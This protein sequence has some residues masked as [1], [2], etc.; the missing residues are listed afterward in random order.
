MARAAPQSSESVT[1][2]FTVNSFPLLQFDRKPIDKHLLSGFAIDWTDDLTLIHVIED[3]TFHFNG[4]AVFRNTDVRR[5]RSV[6]KEEFLARAAQ[7]HKLRPSKP[8]EVSIASMKEALTTAGAAFPVITIHPERTRKG[9]CYV[10]KFART[11][12]RT[13]TLVDM[14]PTAEWGPEENYLLRNITRLSFGGNY[15]NLL[16][17]MAKTPPRSSRPAS[18]GSA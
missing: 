7:L 12:Q 5:W 13:L 16:V 3:H 2:A 18:R 8:P 17:R 10:G 6:R 4:Y 11:T 14:S 9:V 15:E 1:D